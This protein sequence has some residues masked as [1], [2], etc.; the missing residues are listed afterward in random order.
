MTAQYNP[1]IKGD[2]NEHQL[3]AKLY[4]PCANISNEHL[5]QLCA[6]IVRVA[7]CLKNE[8]RAHRVAHGAGAAAGVN[9]PPGPPGPYIPPSD[10]ELNAMIADPNN[11]LFIQFEELDAVFDEINS[12]N[13]ISGNAAGMPEQ[14]RRF[15]RSK[16][17]KA[18]SIV[19]RGLQYDSAK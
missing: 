14:R 6:C 16:I 7:N 12:L 10:A 19:R 11:S 9:A 15:R 5:S 1:S 3:L 4:E 18:N 17:G 8:Q 13:K 2:E